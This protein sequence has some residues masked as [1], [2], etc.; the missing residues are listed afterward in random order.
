MLHFSQAQL[1]DV[2]KQQSQV[3][4]TIITNNVKLP[5][6]YVRLYD[7]DGNFIGNK[8]F[9]ATATAPGE[10]VHNQPQPS[11]SELLSLQ[12]SPIQVPEEPSTLETQL[13]VTQTTVL[14]M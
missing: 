8:S 1:T 9:T 10:Q 7:K 11:D 3:W 12:T 13:S 2:D 4:D 5:S 14:Y 6:P